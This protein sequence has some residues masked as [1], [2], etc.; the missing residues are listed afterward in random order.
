MTPVNLGVC[1]GPSL[2]RPEVET[3]SSIYDIKF[4]NAI[5]ELI[6]KHYEKMFQ[7]KL[8]Q[9]D[10]DEMV[11]STEND[12][13]VEVNLSNS[14][15]SL[16]AITRRAPPPTSDMIETTADARRRGLYNPDYYINETNKHMFPPMPEDNLRKESSSSSSLESLSNVSPSSVQSPPPS[17]SVFSI[18]STLSSFTKQ[19]SLSEAQSRLSSISTSFSTSSKTEPIGG[20]PSLSRT[21]S[22]KTTTTTTPKSQTRGITLYP[23]TADNETELSFNANEIVTQIR[24]SKESGWLLG[25][26][27]GKTGLI[28]EN[29][30]SYTSGV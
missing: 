8:E 20:S 19:L 9:Q 3:V 15:S 5:V 1:F 21:T 4:R 17:S 7:P 14:L 27:N 24:S 16:T 18:R 22:A 29:Y 13:P 12:Q 26:I 6:L 30:I 11:G 10:I 2:L 23:C 28:P 25:T